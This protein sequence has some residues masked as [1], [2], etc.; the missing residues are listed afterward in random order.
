MDQLTV[1]AEHQ[2]PGQPIR[3]RA[4]PGQA[5]SGARG[6]AAEELDDPQDRPRKTR[7]SV[8]TTVDR[9]GWQSR[10]LA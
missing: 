9:K 4:G 6:H 3:P 8:D 1:A 2:E 7:H 10:R 5:G